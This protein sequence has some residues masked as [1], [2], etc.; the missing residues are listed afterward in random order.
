MKMLK[1]L[2]LTI[3]IATILVSANAMADSW[4]VTQTTD[5]SGTTGTTTLQQKGATASSYQT[6]NNINLDT[7]NGTISPTSVQELKTGSAAS[8]LKLDQD[9]AGTTNIQA[10]NNADAA[11]VDGLTQ[12]I[13]AA[14][15]T[16]IQLEQG[17]DSTAGNNNRQAVNR[18]NSNDIKALQQEIK[19]SNISL[20]LDQGSASGGISGGIQAGNLI[21]TTG[22]IATGVKQ[23]VEVS[24]T[25][26]TQDKVTKSIQAANAIAVG[27]GGSL[28][29]GGVADQTFTTDSLVM[30]QTASTAAIQSGNYVGLTLTP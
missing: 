17:V 30:V 26:M 10:I 23:T 11:I 28:T 4:V 20:D 8:T 6:L 27:D 7:T 13:T 18:V 19:S 2:P 3:A 25:N 5:L 16:T 9:G 24:A 15:A 14:A 1:K 22:T 12:K 29:L 21:E